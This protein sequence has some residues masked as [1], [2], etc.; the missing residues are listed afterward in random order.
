MEHFFTPTRRLRDQSNGN[1]VF[2]H[3]EVELSVP[4]EVLMMNCWD[5]SDLLSFI[6]G[7]KTPKIVWITA[8]TFLTIDSYNL[9]NNCFRYSVMMI[10]H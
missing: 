8:D 10:A 7:G 6:T 3:E 2:E 5:W 4:V 1:E 9:V